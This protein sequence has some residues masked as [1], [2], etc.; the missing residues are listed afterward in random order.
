MIYMEKLFQCSELDGIFYMWLRNKYISKKIK[1]SDKSVVIIIVSWFTDIFNA[2]KKVL[3]NKKNKTISEYW[4][5]F[6]L[7]LHFSS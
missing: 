4:R 6:K 5:V 7:S 1:A 2:Q 3:Q